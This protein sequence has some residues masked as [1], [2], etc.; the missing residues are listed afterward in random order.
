VGLNSRKRLI[1]D[2]KAQGALV[3]RVVVYW[4]FSVTAVGLILVLWDLGQGPFGPYYDPARFAALREKY[5]SL[6]VASLFV[7]PVLLA[8]ALLIS[9]RYAGP[10]HRVRQC[11]RDLAAGKPVEHLRFRSRDHFHAL[12]CDFN[13]VADYVNSMKAR[14]GETPTASNSNGQ[15]VHEFQSIQ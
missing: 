13:A 6:F 15:Q 4:V 14:A 9:T 1:V 7:L 11:M 3:L 12:A 5:L 8:D 2:P 10:L